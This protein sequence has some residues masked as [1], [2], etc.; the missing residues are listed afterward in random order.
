MF[1]FCTP[2]NCDALT[3]SP[4]QLT[5]QA[6]TAAD[7]TTSGETCQFEEDCFNCAHFTPA[8]ATL[9]APVAII[10]QAA[11]E[12]YRPALDGIPAIPYHPPRS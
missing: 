12:L 6:Q 7:S 11:P 5:L 2:E 8:P 1:D 9:L 10:A 3:L 4:T